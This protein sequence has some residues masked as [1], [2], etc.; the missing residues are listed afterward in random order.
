MSCQKCLLMF[1]GRD[2]VPF[3]KVLVGLSASAVGQTE[4]GSEHLM[5]LWVSLF[6]AGGSDQMAFEGPFQLKPF[7]DPISC[8]DPFE[9]A[10]SGHNKQSHGMWLLVLPVWCCCDNKR[11]PLTSTPASVLPW[12]MVPAA[13]ACSHAQL[14]RVDPM[15]QWMGRS[16]FQRIGWCTQKMALVTYIYV[17]NSLSCYNWPLYKGPVSSSAL[18]TSAPFV[19]V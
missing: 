8:W 5:E 3:W 15:A 19:S 12:A 14:W 6:I 16:A 2:L 4:R 9:F 17:I 13:P 1:S 7:R 18:S 11:G 10:C